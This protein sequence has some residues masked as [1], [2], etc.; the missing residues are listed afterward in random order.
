MK[1]E[2][3][4]IGM[5]AALSMA[6]YITAFAG[7]E[8]MGA[9][10]KYQN[11]DGVY[12]ANTWAW[13]DGNNDGIAE[14][15]C[16]DENGNLYVNVRTPDQ[17]IVNENGAWTVNGVVQTMVVGGGQYTFDR[18]GD[19]GKGVFDGVATQWVNWV[20]EDEPALRDI[21]NDM[22]GE[23][24]T[25]E[26]LTQEILAMQRADKGLP[27]PQEA[28]A[29][30]NTAPQADSLTGDPALDAAI[31]EAERQQAEKGRRVTAPGGDSYDYNEPLQGITW[32]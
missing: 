20:I 3:V 29:Q 17:Y 32:K 23:L 11:T 9:A 22:Y 15:Y 24:P 2:F 6:S 12:L 26:E 25:K 30:S 10:W 21:M 19:L 7:W 27:A 31:A 4:T 13:I 1:K 28:Q 8:Q 5:A 18:Y 16:F 14:S